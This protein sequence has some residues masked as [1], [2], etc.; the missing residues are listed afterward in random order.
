MGNLKEGGCGEGDVV[1]VGNVAVR[2]DG[3]TT[4]K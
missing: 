1:T 3:K 2:V 4:E